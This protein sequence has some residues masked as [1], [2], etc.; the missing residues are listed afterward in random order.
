MDK[1]NAIYSHNGV[2]FS[3]T[4]ERGSDTRTTQMNLANMMLSEISQVHKAVNAS[5]ST[6]YPELAH[7]W[8]QE[9]LPGLRGV[10]EGA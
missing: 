4:R 8:T 5:T 9:A 10:R 6:K 2:L 3:H 7:S 1:P